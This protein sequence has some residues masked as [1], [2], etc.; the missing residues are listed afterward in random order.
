[1]ISPFGTASARS[2]P[3]SISIG[4][5]SYPDRRV[6][7]YS[8]TNSD[9]EGPIE[10]Q[11]EANKPRTDHKHARLTVISL[12]DRKVVARMSHDR[13]QSWLSLRGASPSDTRRSERSGRSEDHG[14]CPRQSDCLPHL[15]CAKGS[16]RVNREARADNSCDPCNCFC[17]GQG[18][19]SAVYR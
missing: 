6:I 14:T 19:Q 16:W 8:W 10:D 15:G 13:Q 17:H 18:G 12:R 9:S 11:R 7:Q 2:F 3:T 5:G 4:I 1:M